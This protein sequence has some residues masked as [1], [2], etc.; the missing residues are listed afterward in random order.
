MTAGALRH[1]LALLTKWTAILFLLPA[2][3][4]ALGCAGQ[5][6]RR[7]VLL[8]GLG[9]LIVAFPWYTDSISPLWTF[10]TRNLA[11]DYSGERASLGDAAAFYPSRLFTGVLGT[12]LLVCLAVGAWTAK[13]RSWPALLSLLSLAAGLALLTLQPL[14]PALPAGGSG[15]RGRPGL[16]PTAW[17]GRLAALA[18]RRPLLALAGRGAAACG[19]ARGPDLQPGGGSDGLRRA[20]LKAEARAAAAAVAPVLGPASP[21]PRPSPCARLRGPPAGWRRPDRPQ[22]CTDGR[23]R[24]SAIERSRWAGPAPGRLGPRSAVPPPERPT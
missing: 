15:L 7:A 9:G 17:G 12:P 24:R 2:F 6:G 23:V 11:G 19:A 4:L 16:G 14:G 13:G 18:G 3:L 1:G 22:W 20:S 8:A 21:G 5:K 10:L